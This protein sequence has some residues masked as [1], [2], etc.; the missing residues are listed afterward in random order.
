MK[1]YLDLE[2]NAVTNEVISIGMVTE[3]GDEF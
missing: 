1:I 2:A 3:S